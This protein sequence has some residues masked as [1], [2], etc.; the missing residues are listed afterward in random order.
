MWRDM[1]AARAQIKFAAA[2]LDE[3]GY[4]AGVALMSMD[5]TM[6]EIFADLPSPDE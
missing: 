5:V 4:D 6:E 2:Y 3:S 1:N